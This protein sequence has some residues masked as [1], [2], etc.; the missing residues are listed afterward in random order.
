MSAPSNARQVTKVMV[1]MPASVA[2]R[3]STP[4][5]P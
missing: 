3:E 5:V 1:E 4:S 2:K